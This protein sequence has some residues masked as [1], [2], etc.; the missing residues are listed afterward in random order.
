MWIDHRAVRK[1]VGV[2]R[3]LGL[4]GYHLT[5]RRGHRLRGA[6]SFHA[7]KRPLP[8]C[9]SL[10]LTSGL[11]RCFDC[12]V[13]GNQRDLRVPLRSLLPHKAALDLCERAVVR[14]P[15]INSDFAAR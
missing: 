8:R 9:F 7:P 15:A 13:Q 14:V 5:S 1:Q 12:S 4:I 3:A 2:E 11:V 10:E 6:C